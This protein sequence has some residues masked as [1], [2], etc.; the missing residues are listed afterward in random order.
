MC[1]SDLGE[2][3][4]TS[5]YD[6]PTSR[7]NQISLLNR[8]KWDNGLQWDLN[9]KY[10]KSMGS[11][12][13]QTPM[14]IDKVGANSN[15]TLRNQDGT[16]SP[17][18]GDVQSRMSCFNRGHIDEFLLTT[19]LSR[20]HDHM[21]WRIGLNEWF[22]KVNYASNTTMY[23]HTVEAYPQLL[24]GVDNANLNYY[25]NTPYYNLNQNASEIG[26]ASCRERV[27]VL[28]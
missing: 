23:D 5:L 10:D 6:A 19:E 14:A 12:L 7:G 9:M 25:G 21:N 26:R 22:Y 1:S 17:Y 8:Y 28:V 2:I 4:S 20:Q 16:F 27:Y 18:E 15:Y 11:F 3:K 13:Y 24:Y